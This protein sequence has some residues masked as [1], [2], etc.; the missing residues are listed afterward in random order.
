M[1]GTIPSLY[2]NEDLELHRYNHHVSIVDGKIAMLHQNQGMGRP[3][4]FYMTG[5]S[6][7]QLIN[8]LLDA[9]T[10]LKDQEATR[11]QAE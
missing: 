2:D 6:C 7:L 11:G 10:K 8:Q 1:D 4:G 5:V 3:A 9:Y